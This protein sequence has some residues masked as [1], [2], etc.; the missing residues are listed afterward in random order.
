MERE[1]FRFIFF[2]RDSREDAMRRKGAI[3]RRG[4]QFIELDLKFARLEEG[5]DL[6]SNLGCIETCVLPS[7]DSGQALNFGSLSDGFALMREEKYWLGHEFFERF[8]RGTDG[9]ESIFFHGLVLLCVSMVHYQMGKEGNAKRLF[10]R[11][12]NSLSR[13]MDK[14]FAIT[15]FSYPLPEDLIEALERKAL[16]F[17]AVHR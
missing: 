12:V 7:G 11:A 1:R 14:E 13:F 17:I 5:F 9:E 3:V 8:W 10:L 15:V 4:S 2:L 16:G 6:S